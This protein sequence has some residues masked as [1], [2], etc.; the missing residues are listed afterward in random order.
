[1]SMNV[2]NCVLAEWVTSEHCDHNTRVF[3]V[4]IFYVMQSIKRLPINYY[5]PLL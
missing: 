3:I 2:D 1:M 4:F 5:R